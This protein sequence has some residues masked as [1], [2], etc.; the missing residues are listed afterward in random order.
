MKRIS[1]FLLL[2]FL[3]NIF[4]DG[5]KQYIGFAGT[6]TTASTQKE[7]NEKM[8]DATLRYGYSFYENLDLELRGT[9]YI[10][11]GSKLYHPSSLGLFLKPKYFLD[12]DVNIYALLGYSKN[13]LSKQNS[14]TANSISVQNDFS[15]GGGVEIGVSN[16]IYTFVDYVQY[17][18]K[19]VK[20]PEG[21]Y[22]MKI[23]S[24]S[25][26]LNFKFDKEP[27]NS[28]KLKI[29]ELLDDKYISLSKRNKKSNIIVLEGID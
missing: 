29:D 23:N 16:N 11:G 7:K 12:D 5:Y 14:S 15:F 26:G 4:A 19:T 28:K 24:V 1:S 17:I 18:D 20:K 21:T 25:V 13:T 10:A 9:F 22:S 3:T 2:I 27:D 8:V 6:L